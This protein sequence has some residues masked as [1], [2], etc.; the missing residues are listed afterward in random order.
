M[1][2]VRFDDH[3]HHLLRQEYLSGQLVITFKRVTYSVILEAL[4]SYTIKCTPP[5]QPMLLH[6]HH[7]III[8]NPH[9]VTWKQEAVKH[10]HPNHNAGPARAD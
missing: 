10:S 7:H 4:Q 2:G 6:L 5:A 1:T 9:F 8:P 3:H